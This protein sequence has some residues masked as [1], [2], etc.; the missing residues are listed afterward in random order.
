MTDARNNARSADGDGIVGT[1]G[2][3]IVG[4]DGDGIVFISLNWQKGHRPVKNRRKRM[5]CCLSLY[6]YLYSFFIV[7]KNETIANVILTKV[8]SFVL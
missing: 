1:D 4:T 5:N 2:D 7:D 6:L 8:A 3:G